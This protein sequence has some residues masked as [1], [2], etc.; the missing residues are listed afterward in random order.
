MS[1]DLKVKMLG[2]NEFQVSLSNSMSVSELKAKIAQKI[3]V[4]AFQQRLAVHLSGATLQ[5]RVP[6]ANQG[7]GPGSTVLLVVDKCDEPLSILVRNDKGRSSTYE[8]QLTQTVAHLKQQVSRQEGVQ[9]D[10]FWLTFEGKPLENH[11]PLGEYG[12][13]PLSTVFMNLRLRGGGTEPGGR[14]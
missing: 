11:L 12:L 7:L 5:D 1:W 14:S 2:G 6:L 13:K 8:V 9:D 10:L 4:P 3:G